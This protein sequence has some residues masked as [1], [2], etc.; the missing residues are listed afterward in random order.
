MGTVHVVS[1]TLFDCRPFSPAIA[2]ANRDLLPPQTDTGTG[3]M[4]GIEPSHQL[5]IRCW[6]R[7]HL[8]GGTA[9]LWNS[10]PSQ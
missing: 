3:D 4:C 8:S 2:L 7:A 10:N 6:C 1:T 9:T 5:V